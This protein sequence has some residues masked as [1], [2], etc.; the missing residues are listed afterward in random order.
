M[1]MPMLQDRL[2]EIINKLC[3]GK[4]VV[5]GDIILDKYVKGR[6]ER[7][8]PEAP[9]PVLEVE[10]EEL[11]LGGAANVAA[12]I[13]S[14]GGDV[15]LS[16]V[17]GGDREGEEVINL[18]NTWEISPR[19]ILTDSAH[20]TTLKTRLIAHH[21]QM[22][23]M[24]RESRKPV[25]KKLIDRLL[26]R[27]KENIDAHSVLIVSDYSK[28]CVTPH[29]LTLLRKEMPEMRI[30]IDPQVKHAY[31]YQGFY[32][33]TPNLKEAMNILK[34]EEK[35]P[36]K[37]AEGL[38]DKIKAE[39]VLITLGEKGMFLYENN[40][41]FSIPALA[42][43]VFDVTGAGD[44]VVG[45]IGLALSVG[46]S[47]REAVILSNLAAGRV[48]GKLGAS[49]ITKEELK[50]AMEEFAHEIRGYL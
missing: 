47:L 15:F 48:V 27:I 35:D 32:L 28:G 33:L 13:K 20:C 8:S 34:K 4:V 17:I 40:T 9:V 42:R 22:V 39:N 1:N 29:L 5:L 26:E 24:D 50:E 11:R 44:T 21:Q 38:Q 46:A 25:D 14:L 37:L 36:L 12:N 6:V 31:L 23:R 45:V 16:G 2:T 19:G 41:S 49:Q 10:K 43:E 3:R 30:L 18:L 7:I